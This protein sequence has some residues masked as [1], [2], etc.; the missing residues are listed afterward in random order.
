MW[1]KRNRLIFLLVLT[2]FLKPLYATAFE[3]DQREGLIVQ[4]EQ[5]LQ[6][7]GASVHAIYP[8]LKAELEI[9]FGWPLDFRPTVILMK[10]QTAFQIR[11]GS[12]FYSAYA[13]PHQ[14]LIVIDYTKMATRPFLFR[15]TLKHEL[16]HLLLHRHIPSEGLPKWLDE[17]LAQWASGGIAEILMDRDVGVLRKAGLSGHLIPLQNLSSTFPD[18]KDALLLAYEESNSIVDYIEK[19]FGADALRQV[20]AALQA[21]DAIELAISKNLSISLASLQQNWA[22]NLNDKMIWWVFLGGNLSLFLFSIA[23]VATVWGFIRFWFKKKNYKDDDEDGDG[24]LDEGFAPFGMD[25]NHDFIDIDQLDDVDD[26]DH[27]ND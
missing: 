4:Y 1:K 16:T 10:D 12:D 26:L 27:I 24:A 2:V 14:Q 17:G 23:A 7:A 8:T 6:T 9:Q 20:L 15:S 5:G 19:E 21:G 22:R 11:A 25:D 3:A 18:E 13:L